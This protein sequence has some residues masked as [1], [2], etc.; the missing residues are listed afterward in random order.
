ML[1][2]HQLFLR[3]YITIF[4]A[5][6]ITLTLVTYFWAKNLYLNQIE[7][8]L[9]QN[10]DTLSIVLKN[11]NNMN[12]IRSIVRDLHTKLNLRITIIDESGNVIAESDKDLAHINNHANRVEIIQ[13]KNV[14]IGKDTRNSE[15]V[16]KQLLYIAKKI[17]IDTSIYYI[18][19][20]DYTNKI[21]DNFMK[22]TL[23]IFMYIT[24]F[25]IIAFLATYFISLRIKKETDNVLYFLTQLTNKKT[26]FPL[27]ST[28]T[29]EFYKITKLLNK[30]AMKLSKKEKQKAKQTAK[31]KLSNRQKD[32]I[33]SA[34]SHE[35]KNPIAII[36]GYSETILNDEQIPQIMKNKF[37]TK[38]HT[39]ANKMSQII[40]K[41]RL[42]LKLEEG[43]Q[44]LL[45]IPCSMK[46]L[47]ENCISDLKDKYKNREILIIGDDISLKVDET[48][49]SMAISNLIENALKYSENEVIVNISETS[50][51]IVDKGIGIEEKELENINQKFYRISNNGWNNSLGLGLFIVQSIL[52]LHN[53]RLEIK[54]EIKKGSQFYINY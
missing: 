41:L 44:E 39:N 25:L 37:L 6:L 49:I 48:L 53:F 42:T 29:Y 43:K 24:F 31:L 3:T 17:N 46:K 52:N 33:I 2:I 22:L 30:V 36:S 54:S 14:G 1:K 10:I 20:A 13:A 12:N 9:I 27:K 26:S 16:Q 19:M 21:T 40:D 8:N 15:T 28:Y 23:E 38:I 7:K 47:I 11:S 4:A 34:I 45:L 35:F 51:C 5:I 18:R 50:I 32:E